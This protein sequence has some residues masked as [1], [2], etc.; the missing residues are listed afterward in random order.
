MIGQYTNTAGSIYEVRLPLKKEA[1]PKLKKED[2]G[3]IYMMRC[4]NCKYSSNS[5]NVVTQK[6][7]QFQLDT[8][9]YKK[10]PNQ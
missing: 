1:L 5:W 9:N 2:V 3:Q 7:L 6:F 8:K 4:L 10:L